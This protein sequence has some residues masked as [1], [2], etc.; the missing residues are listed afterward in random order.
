MFFYSTET[1]AGKRRE[2]GSLWQSPKPT[3]PFIFTLKKNVCQPTFSKVGHAVKTPPKPR[4]I[5]LHRSDIMLFFV[6]KNVSV[7]VSGRALRRRS[8]F[9]FS[10][11]GFVG[12]REG[13]APDGA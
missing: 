10:F 9:A 4:Q 7:F 6:G 13:V 2:T 5:E 11:G 12:K 3:D 8:I 1:R